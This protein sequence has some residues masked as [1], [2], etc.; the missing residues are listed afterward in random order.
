LDSTIRLGQ[1]LVHAKAADVGLVG[2]GG[3]HDGAHDADDAQ[4][5]EQVLRAG[6][7][8]ALLD[9]A[10]VSREIPARSATM[11]VGS[12]SSFR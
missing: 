5:A 8:L 11:A 3:F 1:D 12:P 10:Q 4:H 7:A 9:G 6:G 2:V